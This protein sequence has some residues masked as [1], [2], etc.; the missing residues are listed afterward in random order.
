MSLLLVIPVLVS[1]N[2]EWV[3]LPVI[4]HFSS[5]EQPTIG[6]TKQTEQEEESAA[7]TA[8]GN[9]SKSKP[10][11]EKLVLSVENLQSVHHRVLESL[12]IKSEPTTLE[13][14]N[15]YLNRLKNRILSY[16]G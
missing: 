5:Q 4:H 12:N 14:K 2:A 13:E 16:I 9:S 10:L 8:H 1:V 6:Q 15:L 11:V 3:Q 7:P